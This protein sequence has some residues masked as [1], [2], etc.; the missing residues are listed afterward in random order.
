MSIIIIV[1][2][3]I[4]TNSPWM[5]VGMVRHSLRA[6]VVGGGLDE[7]LE[8]RLRRS[9]SRFECIQELDRYDESSTN[10]SALTS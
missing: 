3:I 2:I 5:S 7:V 10:C 6:L 9:S 4:I 1:I 8:P